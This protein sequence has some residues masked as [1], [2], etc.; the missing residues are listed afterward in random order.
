M[1]IYTF[2][3]LSISFQKYNAAGIFDAT[4][5]LIFLMMA[6]KSVSPYSSRRDSIPCSLSQLL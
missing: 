4:D 1:Y 5:G 6:A 2:I 3:I